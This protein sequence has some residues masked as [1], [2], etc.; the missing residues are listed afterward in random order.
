MKTI[1]VFNTL[2]QNAQE[3]QSEGN[4]WAEVK[5][6]LDEL[7]I[8]YAGMK[9][10]IG[11]TKHTLESANAIMPAENFSLFLMPIKTKSGSVPALDRKQLFAEM[12]KAV[13]SGKANKEAFMIDGKNMT[14][15]STTT[16]QELWAKH[17][18][19]PV[20]VTAKKEVVTSPAKKES[21]P[22]D[23]PVKEM[24]LEEKVQKS[25]NEFD[26][27][28]EEEQIDSSVAEVILG[29]VRFII[30]LFKIKITEPETEQQKTEREEKERKA[31]QKQLLSKQAEELMK[32]FSDV[33]R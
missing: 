7:K 4:T 10:V 31:S 11:E 23:S 9:A 16:L 24:S 8:P 5:K 21:K 12:K 30:S 14:Q 33:K 22:A 32:D 3:F 17:C 13:E 2:G 20:P 25:Y 28:L 29:K 27:L 15:L 1:T 18:G 19:N 6:E 26:E